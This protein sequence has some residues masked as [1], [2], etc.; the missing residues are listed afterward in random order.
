MIADKTVVQSAQSDSRQV[1]D[2]RCQASVQ[3]P[4]SDRVMIGSARRFEHSLRMNGV[5][6]LHSDKRFLPDLR[7]H[8]DRQRWVARIS[9]HV[10]LWGGTT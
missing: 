8:K 3:T 7:Y 2:A 10:R 9:R 4:P 5:E 6:S 1:T